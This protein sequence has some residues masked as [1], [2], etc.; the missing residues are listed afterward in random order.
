MKLDGDDYR[1]QFNSEATEAASLILE[2]GHLHSKLVIKANQKEY[3]ETAYNAKV[4]QKAKEEADEKLEGKLE[5]ESPSTLYWALAGA[6]FSQA[7]VVF[8]YWRHIFTPD[9]INE[10][11]ALIKEMLN[12]P[13][14]I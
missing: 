7:R 11:K 10:S 5:A 6:A 4:A 9:R 1:F 8:L 13:I 2:P 14:A 12:F 3:D